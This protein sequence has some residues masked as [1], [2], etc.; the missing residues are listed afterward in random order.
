MEIGIRY[1]EKYIPDEMKDVSGKVFYSGRYAF[2]KHDYCGEFL[3]VYILGLNPGGDPEVHADETVRSHTKRIL[4]E[5]ENT[6]SWSA[7]AGESWRR[8]QG[9]VDSGQTAMQKRMMHFFERTRLSD[10]EVPA[11]NLV[12]KRSV[13]AEK[14]K[15]RN[16]LKDLCWPFHQQVIKALGIRVIICLGHETGEYVS[17]KFRKMEQIN[18]FVEQNKRKWKSTVAVSK[19]DRVTIIS[20]THPSR[21]DWTKPETDPSTLVLKTLLLNRRDIVDPSPSHIRAS[22]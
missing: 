16:R 14:L 8:R 2:M 7:W 3:P 10:W 9:W 1:F 17:S 21:A 15:E 5:N 20:L 4:D 6:G 11:S 12:F 19:V 13:N 18:V 22:S